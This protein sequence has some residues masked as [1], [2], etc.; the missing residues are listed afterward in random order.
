MGASVARRRGRLEREPHALHVAEA[1]P[2]ISLQTGPHH[3]PDP[4]RCVRCDNTRT[5]DAQI[6][7]KTRERSGTDI[8]A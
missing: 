7:A 6:A 2:R 8:G 5:F 3:L 1:L 4:R